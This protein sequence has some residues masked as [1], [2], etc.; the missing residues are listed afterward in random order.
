MD[1]FPALRRLRWPRQRI[2]FVQQLGPTDCGAACLS[3][4]LAFYGKILPLDEVRRVSGT[5]RDGTDAQSL[6]RAAHGFGLR[7]RPV[8]VE[9]AALDRLPRASVLYWQFRHF[10]LFDG[11]TDEGIRIVDPAKGP[12]VV[13][14]DRFSESFTGVALILEPGHAFEPDDGKPRR[15][16]WR[17]FRQALAYRGLFSR[18]AVTSALIRLLA[19]AIPIATGALVDVVVPRGDY[20]LLQILA[21]GLAGVVAFH[22]VAELIRAH[23]GLHLRAQLESALTLNFVDRLVDLPY[24]YFQSRSTGDLMV[25]LSANNRIREIIT[26]SALSAVLDGTLVLGYLGLLVLMSPLLGALTLALALIRLALL[27]TIHHRNKELTARDLEV[28][29]RSENYQVEMLGGM[30]SLKSLGAERR[31]AETWSHL[32]VDTLNVAIERGR[33]MAWFNAAV[34][35]LGVLS[36]LLILGTGTW[37][38]LDGTL[39]LGTMLALNALAAGALVP[40]ATMVSTL[41]EFQTLESYLER[42]QEIFDTPREQED[43]ETRPAP[44]LRGEIRIEN[45]TFRYGPLAPTVVRDVSF[46]CRAGEL[47]G[48]VGRTGSGKSTLGKLIAG[49]HLPDEGEILLDDLPLNRLDVRSVRRQLGVV[50]QATHLFAGSV[51]ANI[52]LRDPDIPLEETM[53]AARLADI[54]DDI[55]AMPMGYETILSTAGGSLSGGQRQRL[56]LARALV[57]RPA[58][59]LLDEATSSLDAVTEAR[60]QQNLADLD[61]TRIVIAHRLSAVRDA[62]RIL[63]LDRGE[64]VEEGT[65][66]ELV[67]LGGVYAGLISAQL[68]APT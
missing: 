15:P 34:E 33:M 63:V 22:F 8:R 49:L 59:L 13:P 2:P 65:H 27:L 20:S 40:L 24:D 7:G 68:D 6:L 12:R 41:A 19:L 38:V 53:H 25:R 66:D 18:L 60:V 32:Y 57:Q 9:L 17:Y 23:V 58:I 21:V 10:V 56:A 44:P 1:R 29:S 47:I 62:D 28:Q 67:S 14:H 26:A 61:V 37:L 43:V 50:T 16:I 5:G 35:S 54:H 39:T 55:L 45:V 48:L 31:A 4:V 3:M 46:S 11:I 51:R 30:E 36:P 42:I 52:N 64:L